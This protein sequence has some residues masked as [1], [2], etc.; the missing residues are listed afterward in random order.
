MNVIEYTDFATCNVMDHLV[1][2]TSKD[3]DCNF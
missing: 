3:R 2:A 1:H